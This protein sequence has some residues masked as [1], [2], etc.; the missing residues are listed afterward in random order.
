MALTQ[1]HRHAAFDSKLGADRLTVSKLSGTEAIGRLFQYELD[2]VSSDA[3]IALESLI[4]TNASIRMELSEGTQRYFNGYVTEF[5]YRGWDDG[6]AKYRV[7]MHPWLWFLTRAKDCRVFQEKTVPEIIEFMFKEKHGFLDYD[8]RLTRTYRKRVNCVQYNETDFD[9]VS[10]LMEEEGIYY[11]FEHENASHKMIL[12]D[13]MTAHSVAEGASS[14]AYEQKTR[15]QIEMDI[16]YHIEAEKRVCSGAYA[17]S[18]F[19]FEKPK[20]NLA[21]SVN[22]ETPN[23]A[24]GFEQFHFPGGYIEKDHGTEIVKLRLEEYQATHEQVHGKSTARGLRVGYFFSVTGCPRGDKNREYLL[25][26][27]SFVMHSTG[28]KTGGASEEGFDLSFSAMPSSC[29]FRAVSSTPKPRIVGPQSAVVVGP[30]GEEIHTDEYGRVKVHFH[31]DRYSKADENSSCWIRVSH[32]SA[33]KGYGHI[34]LPRIGQEVIVEFLEGDPDRPIITG[35]VYNGENKPP[36]SLPKDQTRS[37]MKSNSSKGGGGFNEM[38]FEDKA[39]Q[40]EIYMHAQKDMNLHVLNTFQESIGAD[41]HSTVGNEKFEDI[42]KSQHTTIGE[43]LLTEIGGNRHAKIA[44]DEVV[45]VG[46][47][48]TTSV[49]MNVSETTGMDHSLEVGQN[50]YI[51]AGMNIVLEA[52]LN[53][54]LKVGNNFIAINPMGIGMG[55]DAM[56]E[57]KAGAMMTVKSNGM[58]Q[59]EGS[60]M[61]MAKGGVVMIN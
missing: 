45:D 10:R 4:G 39:G 28:L 6:L 43:N 35:R 42:G 60:G 53:I 61:L 11:F 24:A 20:L 22:Y 30:Q 36:Y 26:S 46:M 7:V 17:L 38:R 1:E 59:I 58:T 16:I 9:F 50:L 33:G 12:A 3:D 8:L 32:G 40:E 37:T 47:D 23:A 41:Q 5:N 49:G 56:F 34:V 25:T 14:V 27:A 18:D 54:T 48:M 15:Q 29:V 57:A 31:W 55:S 51:K 2:L 52:G 44:S 21:E 13:S 19:N